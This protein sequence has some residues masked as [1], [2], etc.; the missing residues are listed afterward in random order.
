MSR[1]CADPSAG[2]AATSGVPLSA[3][4]PPDAHMAGSFAADANSFPALPLLPEQA[5]PGVNGACTWTSPG[6]GTVTIQARNTNT[7]TL[8]VSGYTEP[9]PDYTWLGPPATFR[10]GEL[11]A[12]NTNN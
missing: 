4:P 8:W 6:P 7:V 2:G 1:E 9:M 10:V 12:V 11:S 5:E 3:A